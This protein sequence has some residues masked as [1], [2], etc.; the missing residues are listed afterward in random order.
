MRDTDPSARSAAARG[1]AP[2]LA[3]VARSWW[4]NDAAE[5][6]ARLPWLLALL[7]AVSGSLAVSLPFAAARWREARSTAATANWP[8]LGAAFLELAAKG[9]DWKVAG[10]RFVPDPAAPREL[11]AEGWRLRL[12]E[13]GSPAATEGKFLWMGRDLFAIADPATNT[14][15]ASDWRPF[16]GMEGALFRRAAADRSTMTTLVESVLHLAA[17]AAIPGSLLTLL[18][19]MLV[20]NGMFTA[21]LGLFLSLSALGARQG[22]DGGRPRIRLGGAV[23]EAAALA[24]GPAFLAGV[25][26]LLIPAAGAWAWLGYSLLAGIRVVVAYS[27]RWQSLRRPRAIVG[28]D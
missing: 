19:L 7:L 11:A 9:G 13:A 10:G 14:S 4:S 25:A 12:G 20:Q 2:S 26:G 15:L 21:M 16:E 22:P 5:S 18:L 3:L 1:A 23:K 17:T 24:A 6:C 28:P 27:A 8:G